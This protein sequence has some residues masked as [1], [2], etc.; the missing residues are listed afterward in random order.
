MIYDRM[1][2]R[3]HNVSFQ[4]VKILILYCSLHNILSQHYYKSIPFEN[5]KIN[6]TDL[7]L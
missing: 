2:R 1:K 6:T 4:H 3:E 7:I 5:Y